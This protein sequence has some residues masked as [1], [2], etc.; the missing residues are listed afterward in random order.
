MVGGDFPRWLVYLF[1]GP[2]MG[3]LSDRRGECIY[4]ACDHYRQCFIERTRRRSRGS[5]IV[6][7]NHAVT[8][9]E[10][11][12]RQNDPVLPRHFIFDEGHHLFA[13]A[14]SA[15]SLHLT[16]REGLEL[17]SWL[18]GAEGRRRGRVRGVK[19]R[20]EGLVTA[21]AEAARLLAAICKAALGLPAGGWLRRVQTSQPSGPFEL[22]LMHVRAHVLAVHTS[23]HHQHGLEAPACELPGEL[24]ARAEELAR[25]LEGLAA[26]LTALATHLRTPRSSVPI[27]ASWSRRNSTM[28]R[29]EGWSPGTR[30]AE[31]IRSSWPTRCPIS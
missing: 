6:I 11:T 18:L 14:D 9:I 24:Q 17:R 16:G 13:A 30:S 21:D 23:A 20:L 28:H 22:F 4:S 1:P 7:A 31:G 27:R 26:P 5:H 15:F 10:A 29:V 2:A 25:A 19:A 12:L 8:L 3:N